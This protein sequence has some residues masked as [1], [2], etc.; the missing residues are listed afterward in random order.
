MTPPGVLN[1]C[2]EARLALGPV[3]EIATVAVRLGRRTAYQVG[4]LQLF[5]VDYIVLTYQ[6]QCR[7]VMKVGAL[8]LDVLIR[9]GSLGDRFLPAIA[10][11]L[12]A[13]D[14][15]IDLG[16]EPLT[17]PEVA[18]VVYHSPMRCDQEHFQANI[19]ARLTTSRRQ[20]LHRDIGTGEDDV[21][22]I[23]FM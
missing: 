19:Y 13:R 8:P 9:F 4:D 12:A 23:G 5:E 11:L 7:L 22:P 18:R 20:R 14:C 10:A 6:R 1:R 3:G 15:L 21:P 17:F 2:I 16:D